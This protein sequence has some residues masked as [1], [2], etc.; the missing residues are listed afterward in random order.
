MGDLAVYA[1]L[2][3]SFLIYEFLGDL[4][5]MYFLKILILIP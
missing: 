5:S 3:I 1:T 2:A 4:N